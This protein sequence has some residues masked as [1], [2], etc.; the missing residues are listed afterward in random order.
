[1]NHWNDKCVIVTGGTSGLGRSLVLKLIG[2]GAKVAF[3]GRSEEKMKEVLNQ[4][5]LEEKNNIYYDTFEITEENK[6]ISFVKNVEEKLGTVD[7][8]I[9]CAGANTARSAVED[10]K[11]EDID[12]MF[13]LNTLAPLTF[14]KECYKHMKAKKEGM[15]VNI[16][17][18]CCLYSNEGLGAYTA[19]KDAFDGL[20]KVLRK[21][22]RKNNIR[23]C[24]V[25][26]G[27]INT[28]FREQVREEY[29][30]A[31]N[32]A[33]AILKTLDIDKAVALDEIV[34]RPFVET[35]YC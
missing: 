27:G 18:T 29:L 11:I 30:S 23:V 15:I 14:I 32:T 3:C 35:N 21:E 22:A 25:Y 10:I 24:S 16:L 12:F 20:T 19:S 28:S 17:S 7:A 6:I 2:L 8:L 9:N 4:I 26:P 31:N 33:E 34:L 5:N 1:M 13:K